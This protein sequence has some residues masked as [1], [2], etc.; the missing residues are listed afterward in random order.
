MTDDSFI[1]NIETLIDTRSM[2]EVVAALVYVSR[3]YKERLQQEGNREYMGWENWEQALS[4][5][6]NEVEG[7]DGLSELLEDFDDAS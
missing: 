2:P 6:I 5:A 7:P 4:A 1:S 3:Q